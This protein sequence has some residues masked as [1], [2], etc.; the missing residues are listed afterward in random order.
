MSTHWQRAIFLLCAALLGGCRRA[1]C[2]RDA[3]ASLTCDAS[4]QGC[5]G[6]CE[7]A[8]DVVGPLVDRP[9]LQPIDRPIV[10]PADAPPGTTVQFTIETVRLPQSNFRCGSATAIPPSPSSGPQSLFVID[11]WIYMSADGTTGRWNRQTGVAQ[12]FTSPESGGPGYW[13]VLAAQGSRIAAVLNEPYGERPVGVNPRWAHFAVFDDPLLP[14]RLLR[15]H[16]FREGIGGIIQE[17]VATTR[18]MAWVVKNVGSDYHLWISGPD[19]ENPHEIEQLIPEP[20]QPTYLHADGPNL[21][22]MFRGEIFL[23]NVERG[24]WSRRKSHQRC[25]MAVDA[26]D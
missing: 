13:G 21:V 14:G 11:E 16:R 2:A 4:T 20:H 3:A 22:W 1:E 23:W 26:V 19:G 12:L 8:S 24:S 5:D 10:A 6:R 18:M 25:A 15:T 9:T 7:P 17:F